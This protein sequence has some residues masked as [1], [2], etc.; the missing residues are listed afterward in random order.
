MREDRHRT[1][2]LATLNH[3][4]PLSSTPVRRGATGSVALVGL[5]SAGE[6]DESADDCSVGDVAEDGHE[7]GLPS[8]VE[9]EESGR[10]EEWRGGGA[11]ERTAHAGVEEREQRVDEG[12]AGEE[13]VGGAE[14]GAHPPAA[15]VDGEEGRI[16]D[17]CEQ[18]PE[19]EVQEVAERFCAA[20][21]DGER[22]A[23]QEREVDAGEFQLV[24]GAQG[25]GEDEGSD[26]AAC[27]S[28]VDAHCSVSASAAAALISARWLSP[29][30]ML[31]R[32]APLPGSISS[33]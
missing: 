17:E 25:G 21:V 19:D 20:A 10:L 24:R 23:E 27:K 16:V 9:H 2:H 18:H 30:G 13:S 26:E 3:V 22:G 32:K 8:V 29:C 12:G 14:E 28:A 33:L 11:G 6:L 7:R 31:P 15:L 5:R 4:F 1:G